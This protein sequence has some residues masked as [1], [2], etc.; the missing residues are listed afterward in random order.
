MVSADDEKIVIETLTAYLNGLVLEALV[1]VIN[2]TIRL[3]KGHISRMSIPITLMYLFTTLN[4]GIRWSWTRSPLVF[5]RKDVQ[6]ETTYYTFGNGNATTL[7]AISGAATGVSILIADSILIWRCWIVWGRRWPFVILPILLTVSGTALDVLFIYHNATDKYSS[8]GTIWGS[9]VEWGIIFYSMSLGTTIYCTALI[10]FRI[11]AYREQYWSVIEMVV[12]SAVLYALAL[13][14]FIGFLATD[15]ANGLYPKALL[16]TVAGI[17]PTLIVVRVAS[18]QARSD[19]SWQPKETSSSLRF[20]SSLC[21]VTAVEEEVCGICSSC[22][23]KL[24]H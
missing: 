24:V 19:E 20:E 7:W 1:H 11:L 2:P 16:D 14:V 10:I 18:G 5:S 3:P 4:L 12:E 6:N 17:A 9:A 22:G 15:D 13:V 21:T 8:D 23:Q